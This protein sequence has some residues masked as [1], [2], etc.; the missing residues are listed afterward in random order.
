[1]NAVELALK[2]QLLLLESA[3]QREELSQHVAGLQPIF[4]VADRTREGVRWISRHPET[5]AG[6]VALLAA[7]R[8]S[9]RRF[10][11]RWGKRAFIGW[12]LLRES[13]FWRPT[14]PPPSGRLNSR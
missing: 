11:W 12:Q 10:L 6:G 2:K 1:M 5:V 4:H 14:T 3:G 13:D 8:P 7:A 9:V